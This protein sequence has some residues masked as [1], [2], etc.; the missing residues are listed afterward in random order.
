[1]HLEGEEEEEMRRRRRRKLRVLKEI[2]E[3]C[4]VEGRRKWRGFEGE[5]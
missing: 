4:G 5:R 3:V 2:Y 1:M